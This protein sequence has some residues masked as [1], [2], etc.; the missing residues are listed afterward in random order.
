MKYSAV[1]FDL[2]GTLV[3][4][5][6]F[7]EYQ[8]MLS[9]M[10]VAVSV[11]RE[12]LERLWV[13]TFEARTK[14]RF[15]TIEANIEHI[16]VALGVNANADQVK[17]AATTRRDFTRR[18]LAPKPDA[19]QTLAR[20]K[21]SGYKTGLIS[22]CSPEVPALWLDTPFARLVDVPIF[23][24]AV[25]IKKPDP[26]I[27]DLACERLGVNPQDCL[28][29]GDGSSRELTGASQVG[30]HAVLISVA[31]EEVFDSYDAYRREARDWKG[32]VISTL[33]DVLTMLQ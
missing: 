33:N 6:S 16:C 25:G 18:S 13:D 28:Y 21:A 29:V 17:A 1:I 12:D 9:E 10:A 26:R 30:M 11:A 15:A 20:L 4:D 23:S 14:G 2:F 32:P 27:Y 8:R 3:D 5:F 19:V 22:D 24:A 7:T 31:Y